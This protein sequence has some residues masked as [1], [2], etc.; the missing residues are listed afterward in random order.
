MK[1]VSSLGSLT[2]VCFFFCA[3]LACTKTTHSTTTVYDTVVYKN[4]DTVVQKDTIVLALPKLIGTW[5]GT[6]KVN[7]LPTDSFS[8]TMYIM[9]NDTVAEIGG[10]FGG[11]TVGSEIG[12]WAL[13]GQSFSAT[14][15]A[16]DGTSPEPIQTI[17]ATYDS[18]KGELY[19]GVF[20]NSSGGN[21]T[22][23]GTF[24]LHKVD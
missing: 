12:P 21:V 11:A 9:A 15:T 8:E 22:A 3:V 10:G 2:L 5:T 18:V 4:Y 20:S 1:R 23:T 17:T 24:Y 13:A 16:L 19:N 7:G 6:Y 14:M